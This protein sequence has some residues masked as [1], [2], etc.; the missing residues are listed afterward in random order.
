MGGTMSTL[1]QEIKN[2]DPAAASVLKDAGFQ[3][4]SEIQSLTPED[5][6]ELFPGLE[7]LNLRNKIFEI[8][9]KQKRTHPLLD[10][11]KGINQD[12]FRDIVMNKCHGRIKNTKDQLHK[13]QTVLERYDEIGEDISQSLDSKKDQKSNSKDEVDKMQTDLEGY[14]EIGEDISQSLDSK[15]EADFQTDSLFR[16]FSREDLHLLFPEKKTLKLRKT[17][18]EIMHNQ[19]PTHLFLEKLQCFIQQD[20]LKDAADV[21]EYLDGIKNTKDQLNK[22]Q[23]VLNAYGKMPKDINKSQ[24]SGKGSSSDPKA[25]MT[26]NEMHRDPSPLDN[27]NMNPDLKK[28]ISKGLK[29]TCQSKGPG[30]GCGPPVKSTGQSKSQ[31]GSEKHRNSKQKPPVKYKMLVCGETFGAHL[32]LLEQIQ[33]SGLKLIKGNDEESC[34]TIVF[35]PVVTRAG[36][37]AEAAMKMVPGNNPVILVLMHYSQ[38]PKHVSSS[39]VLTSYRNVNLE[40]N[41]FY[42]DRKKGL[43]KCEGNGNAVMQLRDNLMKYQKS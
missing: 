4:D 32:Q 43:L 7:A 14:A 9:D 12:L 24:V 15:K 16:T 25:L 8:I 42:H 40:V 31:S 17:I 2:N 6:Y 27:T 10:D 29:Q 37:D 13:M 21:T 23:D 38:E 1:L 26:N 3:T 11:Y 22:M 33:T 5:M 28:N 41:V 36:T 18:S 30:A 35:C 20:S 19:K 34:I 39:E